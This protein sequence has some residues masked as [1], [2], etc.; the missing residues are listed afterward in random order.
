MNSLELT[1]ELLLDRLESVSGGS[2]NADNPFVKTT[3][4]AFD[5]AVKAGEAARAEFFRANGPMGSSI[6]WKP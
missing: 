5:D 6:P 4:K 3:L 1:S 2:R